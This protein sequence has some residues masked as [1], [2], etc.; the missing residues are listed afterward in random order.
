[1]KWVQTA[2]DLRIDD[3]QDRRNHIAFLKKEREDAIAADADRTAKMNA[4][5]EDAKAVSLY[6][7]DYI[8]YCN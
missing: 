5:H 6:L 3:V 8:G 4:A 1:M 7:N 2:V